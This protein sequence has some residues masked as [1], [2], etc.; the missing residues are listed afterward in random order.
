MVVMVERRE[1][2]VAVWEANQVG[3]GAA[4]ACTPQPWQQ[5]LPF[6]LVRQRQVAP[7]A[8]TIAQSSGS[9]KGSSPAT[10][11][12]PASGG[13]L[14]TAGPKVSKSHLPLSCRS[15]Y[16]MLTEASDS[17]RNAPRS[18]RSE[19][20]PPANERSVE[21]SAARLVVCRS[22]CA[23]G[24]A[25]ARAGWCTGVG[26]WAWTRWGGGRRAGAAGWQEQE[27]TS[28]FTSATR[29]VQSCACAACI[30]VR[31]A[32]SGARLEAVTCC[33][34]SVSMLPIVVSANVASPHPR[35]T[36][37]EVLKAVVKHARSVEAASTS[38]ITAVAF[39][40]RRLVA[41]LTHP[42]VP[43]VVLSSWLA[44]QAVRRMP[45]SSCLP[46]A[47]PRPAQHT[48]SQP[49]RP[50]QPQVQRRR[51]RDGVS[52][53]QHRPDGLQQRWAQHRQMNSGSE[54]SRTRPTI[55]SP[56]M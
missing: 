55:A 16:A 10:L 40:S 37:P 12:A 51:R 34:A 3:G 17:S 5:T 38:A 25:G 45:R 4:S 26:V 50:R 31:T 48:M 15:P 35:L 49:K 30:A 13:R 28:G 19:P 43:F 41:P 53:P 11:P 9:T 42:S 6:F 18:A 46:A 21:R 1:V 24:Q 36:A 27:R 2:A 29:E 44:A 23:P 33:V 32:Y 7:H 22:I 20:S 47:P 56:P 14:A 52:L 8:P 39:A 54:A